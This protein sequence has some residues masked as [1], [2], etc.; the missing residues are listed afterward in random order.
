M[1]KQYGY[2][3][4]LAP[5]VAKACLIVMPDAASGK[6]PYVNLDSVRVVKLIGGDISQSTVV[7]GM[8]LARGV[9][10]RVLILLT[11]PY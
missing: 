6:R 3:D 4:V 11:R 7:S 8:L 1:A 5:L 10:V 9:E 2:E